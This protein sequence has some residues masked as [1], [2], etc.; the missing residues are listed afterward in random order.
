MFRILVNLVAVYLV[1]DSIAVILTEMKQVVQMSLKHVYILKTTFDIMFRHNFIVC[2]LEWT[3]NKQNVLRVF[4]ISADWAWAGWKCGLALLFNKIF[5][6]A[7][8]V[9]CLAHVSAWVYT[10]FRK[11]H[12]FTFSFISP[13]KMFRFTQNFQ[14]MFPRNYIFYGHKH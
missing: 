7:R 12:P 4:D 8:P 2:A 11:K 9:G 6:L 3:L 5:S 10:V 13:W 1:C 14:G